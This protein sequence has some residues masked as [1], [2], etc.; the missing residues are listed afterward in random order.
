[1]WSARWARGV[2]MLME[3]RGMLLRGAKPGQGVP[4]GV[5]ER[6]SSGV[7]IHAAQPSMLSNHPC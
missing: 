2:L 3:E 4:K 6:Q 7:A 5:E 1:M